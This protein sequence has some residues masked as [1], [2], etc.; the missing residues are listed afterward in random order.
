MGPPPR[1]KGPYVQQT[2]AQPCGTPPTMAAPPPLLSKRTIAILVVVV[3]L[4]SCGVYLLRDRPGFLFS[5]KMILLSV[6]LSVTPTVVHRLAER[7]TLRVLLESVFFM[8]LIVAFSLWLFGLSAIGRWISYAAGLILLLEIGSNLVE[9]YKDATVKRLTHGTASESTKDL[10]RSIEAMFRRY[11]VFYVSVPAG[12]IL[13]TIIELIRHDTPRAT[14]AYSVFSILIFASI[15]LLI[16]LLS[17]LGRIT[18]PFLKTTPFKKTAPK[19]EILNA[20]I[21]VTDLRKIYLYNGT[22]DSVLLV[23]FAALIASHWGLVIP[24]KWLLGIMLATV[25]L[26]NQLPYVI[27]QYLL[28]GRVLE[29]FEGLERGRIEED[30]KKYTPF[31]PTMDFITAI[32]G[33]G[34]AGGLL[35][36]LFDGLLKKV[37]D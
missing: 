36:F 33:T 37:F 22:H 25:L 34:T 10:A 26:L 2:I 17:T 28:Y 4:L 16:S 9:R 29:P 18:A 30:L 11:L 24:A 32:L 15:V 21:L 13:G 8:V 6:S 23:A 3:L 5:I 20:S 1:I 31:F 7:R 19:D 12:L 14:L 27:G 35:L